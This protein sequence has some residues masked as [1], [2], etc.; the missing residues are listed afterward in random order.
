M[1]PPRW[2]TVFGPLKVFHVLSSVPYVMTQ[3]SPPT[4]RR[5][6]NRCSNKTCPWMLRATLFP[7]AQWWKQPRCPSPDEWTKWG[8]SIQRSIAQPQ[9]GMR[10]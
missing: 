5:T 3:H 9:D 10:F 4:S 2:K 1:V 8:L 6:G 7:A